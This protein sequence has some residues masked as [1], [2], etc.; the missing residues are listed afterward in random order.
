MSPSAAKRTLEDL[1][2]HGL[3]DCTQG[4]GNGSWRL[5]DVARSLMKAGWGDLED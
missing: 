3:A 4:D 1:R 2:L 5:S